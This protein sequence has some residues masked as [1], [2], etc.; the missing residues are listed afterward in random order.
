MLGPIPFSEIENLKP[1]PVSTVQLCSVAANPNSC[2]GDIAKIVEYDQALAASAIRVA[3][4]T[5]SSPRF[6]IVTVKE[7]V[8]RI[9]STRVLGL[10][11]SRHLE[12]KMNKSFDGYDLAELELWRHSIATAL[13]VDNLK[14]F[15]QKEIP[16][17]A[18]AAAL[19]HDVGKL[20]VSQYIDQ[21]IFNQIQNVIR[22]EKTDYLEAERFV[23]GTDHAEVGGAIA[24]YW[25][26]PE[27][28]V[29][30]IKKHH[31]D[32]KDADPVIDIVQLANVVAKL[33]GQ[34]LGSEQMNLKINP[35]IPKRLALKESDL[36][37][38]CALVKM[39]LA[40]AEEIYGSK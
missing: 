26:F 2:I 12:N 5:W 11:I 17:A 10:A 15:T 18:F 22:Q 21:D 9:G 39:K 24:Q 16:S 30:A 19:L 27:Q 34:G 20:I 23:L 13:A 31:Q 7:A 4:S 33:I 32:N 6:P 35:D 1:M 36:E 8:L 38:L 29:N 40:E 28:L 3:N 25:K 37:T 14:A